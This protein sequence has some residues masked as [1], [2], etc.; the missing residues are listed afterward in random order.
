[1][2]SAASMP[3]ASAPARH[4]RG[5]ETWSPANATLASGSTKAWPREGSG[6]ACGFGKQLL[7]LWRT[8]PQLGSGNFLPPR[9]ST[10][11]LSRAFCISVATAA[12]WSLLPEAGANCAALLWDPKTCVCFAAKAAV[13]WRTTAANGGSSVCLTTFAKIS[14]LATSSMSHGSCFSACTGG[15]SSPAIDHAS[16]TTCTPWNCNWLICS[17]AAVRPGLPLSFE[18]TTIGGSPPYNIVCLGCDMVGDVTTTQS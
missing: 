6:F 9:R 18:A 15:A 8:G 10:S 5:C 2:P 3:L 11:S 12:S 16:M 13:E 7:H 4:P 14:S 17:T 1:M